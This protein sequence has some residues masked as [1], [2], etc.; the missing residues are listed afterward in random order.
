MSGISEEP[1]GIL[2]INY[3]QILPAF[4]HDNLPSAQQPF[5]MIG[6]VEEDETFNVAFSNGSDWIRLGKEE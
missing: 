5:I 6:I 4:S 3:A 1:Q 2:P